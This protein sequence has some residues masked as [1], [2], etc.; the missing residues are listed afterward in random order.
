[1]K[2]DGYK[3]I[4]ATEGT[5]GGGPRIDGTRISVDVLAENFI[6]GSSIDKNIEYYP[7][8]NR[9]M[10]EEALRFWMR[11]HSESKKLDELLQKLNC[12]KSVLA[13]L[14]SIDES[15][16]S[17][18]HDRVEVLYELTKY[19]HCP[20]STLHEVLNAHVFE[21]LEGN[22]DSVLSALQ[23]NKYELA[24]L[25][26]IKKIAETQVSESRR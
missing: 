3:Y 13:N 22:M 9:E 1:M 18:T 5:L 14:L 7:S 21:D 26:N 20:S 16:V 25:A 17:E 8:L 4:V 6:A 24:T 15:Q 11:D 19:D 12:S 10:I 23:Q 2:F